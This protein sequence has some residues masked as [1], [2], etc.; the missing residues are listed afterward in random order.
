[1]NQKRSQQV[2][3]KFRGVSALAC[4]ATL[5]LATTACGNDNST[6]QSTQSV[7]TEPS[8]TE[9]PQST[10]GTTQGNSDLCVLATALAGQEGIPT[11]D[12]LTMYKTLAPPEIA[13]AANTAASAFLA[14]GGDLVRF[15]IA[16][17]NDDVAQSLTEINAWETVNCGIDHSDEPG[18]PLRGG[19]TREREAGTTVVDVIAT[20]FAFELGDETLTA[21]RTSLVLTNNGR[22]AH[23]IELFKL[24]EG[25]TMEQVML[26]ENGGEGL[27]DG[28]WDSGAA[29]PGGTDEE[30]IT[31]DLE[32]GTYGIACYISSADGVP[33]A[34]SGMTAQFTVV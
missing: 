30:V 22:E 21:G 31:L 2:R 6:E 4:T 14:A 13:D 5:T 18:A 15:Y 17:A 10:A 9:A 27:I 16:F 28:F 12:Q 1:M 3:W 25:V 23:F 19:A 26:S 29:A 8:A 24:A 34:M 11:S 7:V 32:P 33:H 20:D